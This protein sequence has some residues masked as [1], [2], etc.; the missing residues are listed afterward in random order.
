MATISG[1]CVTMGKQYTFKTTRRTTY[2]D[3]AINNIPKKDRSEL[4][5]QAVTIGLIQMGVLDEK[6]LS[7]LD[8]FI[9]QTADNS[10]TKVTQRSDKETT[11]VEQMSYES[12]TFVEQKTHESLTF[13]PP[14]MDTVGSV[15]ES[16]VDLDTK[17][18]NFNF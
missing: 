5:R 9:R 16:S 14:V 8:S 10:N 18:D 7:F 1:E 17:L 6:Q 15:D 11:I 13:D 3:D 12:P 4:L 2:L